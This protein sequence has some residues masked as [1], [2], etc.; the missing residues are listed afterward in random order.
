MSA[1]P[2]VID[3]FGRANLV[4]LGE[5]HGARQDSEFRLRLIRHP[6][7]WRAGADIVVEFANAGR[8]EILDRFIAG[9]DVSAA[10]LANI[11]R[12]TTQPGAWDSPVYEQFLREV[13]QVNTSL[14]AADRLR[15]LAGDPPVDW[16]A[17]DAQI[18]QAVEGRDEFAASVMEREVLRKDRKALVVFGTLHLCRRRSGTLAELLR[19]DARARWFSIIPLEGD[20]GT[21]DEP[22]LVNLA[23]HPVGFLEANE[24]FAKG[25]RRV[26][27]VDGKVVLVPAQ[28]FEP[29]LKLRDVADAGLDFGS[30]PP[31]W[32]PR[33]PGVAGTDYGT[34]IDRRRAILMRLAQA[35]S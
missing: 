3:A 1:V 9:G 10:E 20:A 8:Q 13:R 18:R 29:D 2:Q 14:P 25:T 35:L 28:V 5:R 27:V 22:A 12:D 32:V 15:V 23:G 30:E 11:W 6:A 26:Q 21:P 34:E 24:L 7:F 31:E 4:G 17:P 33:P 16:N 19:G